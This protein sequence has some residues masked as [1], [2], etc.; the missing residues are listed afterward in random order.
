MGTLVYYLVNAFPDMR[1]L[2]YHLC[3]SWDPKI[4]PPK[5]SENAMISECLAHA[6]TYDAYHPL[7]YRS[8]SDWNILF[9]RVV[10]GRPEP[11]RAGFYLYGPEYKQWHRDNPGD[12]PGTW[13]PE[14]VCCG[15]KP[16]QQCERSQHRRHLAETSH[17]V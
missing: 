13:T 5:G 15:H 10:F 8:H 7:K 12:N 6:D 3:T 16:G 9:D 2:P 4:R 14:H 11:C 17:G 1:V